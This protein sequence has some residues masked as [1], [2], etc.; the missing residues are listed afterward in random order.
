MGKIRRVKKCNTK[1]LKT[2]QKVIKLFNDQSEIA[3]EGKYKTI[4]G[5][6]HPSDLAPIG[7]VSDDSKVFDRMQLKI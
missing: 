6:G 7:K 2:L 3:S 5:E 1:Y 4:Y